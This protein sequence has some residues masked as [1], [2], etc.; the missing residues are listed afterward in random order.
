[1]SAA[2]LQKNVKDTNLPGRQAWRP[3]LAPPCAAL[4]SSGLSVR[5]RFCGVLPRAGGAC[6]SR[7][8][9]P[10]ATGLR[11]VATGLRRV[12]TELRREIAETGPRAA[13]RLAGRAQKGGGL[14]SVGTEARR[15]AGGASRAASALPVAVVMRRSRAGRFG[16]AVVA[17][18]PFMLVSRSVLVVARRIVLV[19]VGVTDAGG[20]AQ[21]EREGKKQVKDFPF[22]RLRFVGFTGN[23]ARTR[24]RR[25]ARR[26]QRT[27]CKDS[28]QAWFGPFP[29]PYKMFSRLYA[30]PAF[31]R[32]DK[33]AR[34]TGQS[35]R[36]GQKPECSPSC[37]VASA[38][39]TA[40]PA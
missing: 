5:R 22:H 9:G 34:R 10:P 27:L 26:G 17:L 21:A 16:L 13:R 11:R 14:Q 40:S 19:D 23:V 38:A 37:T 33:P 1:M 32:M 36:R 30:S 29:F 20:E 24:R 4:A 3:G 28:S 18:R 8:E 25:R 39:R 2:K 31:R 35:C 6:F 15:V 12:A 7:K